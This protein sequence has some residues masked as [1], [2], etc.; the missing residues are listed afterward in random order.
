MRYEVRKKYETDIEDSMF[1]TSDDE[2]LSEEGWPIS[3]YRT[4]PRMV[5]D[6]GPEAIMTKPAMRIL[7]WSADRSR[8]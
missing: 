2:F 1:D 6:N 3:E 5:A 7:I 8:N 4:Q